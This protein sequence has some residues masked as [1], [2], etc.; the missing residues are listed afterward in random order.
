MTYA[1]YL[2]RSESTHVRQ[3]GTHARTHLTYERKIEPTSDEAAC[4]FS[5][6]VWRV[7][8]CEC[9]LFVQYIY[10]AQLLRT[11]FHL[12]IAIIYTIFLTHKFH[13]H[14]TP[15]PPP[16]FTADSHIETYRRPFRCIRT[17]TFVVFR[18][19]QAGQ[20]LFQRLHRIGVHFVVVV[21][22][23]LAG[24][25]VE[26]LQHDVRLLAATLRPKQD[27]QLIGHRADRDH[28]ARR[29]RSRRHDAVAQ[30]GQLEA[31]GND[32]A[33]VAQ[34]VCRIDGRLGEQQ[35]TRAIGLLG[36]NAGLDLFEGVDFVEQLASALF[37]ELNVTQQ[38]GQLIADGGTLRWRNGGAGRDR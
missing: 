1:G 38:V 2:I 21:L 11:C 15:V 25:V 34:S 28:N 35:L 30:C 29:C 33:S 5:A 12:F 18:T 4:K 20:R 37:D 10:T 31:F 24:A 13:L 8:V 36:E 9:L 7:F 3:D 27:A 32:G 17:D 6:R 19:A 23:R 22:Q 26:V 14:A 16:L